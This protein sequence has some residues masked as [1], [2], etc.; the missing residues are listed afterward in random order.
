MAFGQAHV[1][2]R[3]ELDLHD[4]LVPANAARFIKNLVSSLED[5]SGESTEGG[6]QTGVYKPIKSNAPYVAD[7]TPPPGN[8]HPIGA[9]SF[10]D[11]KQVFFFLYNDQQNFSVY[12]I[13][14]SDQTIDTVYLKST[15]NF[16]LNPENFIHQGAC[17][18]E[19]INYTDPT[20]G[21]TEERTFL[22]FT[23]NTNPQRAICVE[24]SIATQG[25]NPVIFPYFSGDYDPMI[26]INMGVATPKG[27]IGISEVPVTITSDQ[28]PNKLLYNTWQFRLRDYD[29]WG[30]PSQYGTISDMYIPSTDCLAMSSG[31]PNCLNLE[32]DA[33]PPHINQIEIAFR[34]C[35]NDQWYTSK[36]IDLYDASPLG[37]WWTRNRNPSVNY[38]SNTNKITFQFCA[39]EECDVIAPTDADT[40]DNGLPKTSMAVFPVGQYIGLANNKEGFNPIPKATLDKITITVEPPS[41]TDPT[42]NDFRNVTIWVQIYNFYI[43][44]GGSIINSGKFYFQSVNQALDPSY[45]Q[46]FQNV[47]Q[48]GFIGY[49]AGTNTYAISEQYIMDRNGNFQKITD[50]KQNEMSLLKG[51][52]FQKFTFTNISKGQYIFRIAGLT[53]DPSV[54]SP[55]TIFKTSTFVHGVYPFNIATPTAPVGLKTP[56]SLNK[57][58]LIDV[59]AGDY[60][61]TVDG[62]ILVIADFVKSATAVRAGY[63]RNTSDT[64][65]DQTGIELLR[66]DGGNFGSQFTDHNGY[67]FASAPTDGH[68]GHGFTYNIFGYC[69]CNLISLTN[70]RLSGYQHRLTIDNW[71]QNTIPNCTDLPTQICRYTLISGQ[72]LLCGSSI[73]VPGI[74]VILS[75][76]NSAITD[77][78]GNF[79]IVA[80]DDCTNQPRNDTIY[81]VSNTCN[82]SDCDGNCIPNIPVV[83]GK[84]TSC[85]ARTIQLGTTQVS[86]V[87]QRGPLS[88]GVYAVGAGKFDWLQRT[89]FIDP[90][91]YMT[92]P[93]VQQTGKFAPSRVR[94][95]I[96]PT[97]DFPLELTDLTIW[98]SQ[99]TTIANY[100]TWIV[101]SFL[102]VDNTGLENTTNPTQ[103][104]IYYAS[105]VEYNKQNN[106]NTTV[107]WSFLVANSTNAVTSDKVEFLLNGDGTFFSKSIT[108]LVKYDTVGQF[109][110]INYTSDLAGLVANAIIRLVRPKVCTGTEPYYECCTNIP[111]VNGKATVLS[112]YLN[113]FDTYYVYRQIPVPVAQPVIPPATTITFID[114]VRSLGVPFETNSP[115]DFWGQG[116]AN[117]GRSNTKNEQEVELYLKDEI[118]ISGAL[119]ITNQ[120]NFLNYFAD[121]LKVNFN[122]TQING[123]TAV[124]FETTVG[125]V[126]GSTDHFV[127]GFNDNLMR[128]NQDGTAQAGSITNAFGNPYRK[129]GSNFGCLP[130]DKN[131]IYK[132]DGLVHWLDTSK[133][134]FVQHNYSEAVN[135]AKANPAKGIPGG[136][137]SWLRPKIKE[138]QDFNLQNGNTRYFHG[139]VNPQADEYILTDFTIGNPTSLNNERQ[140]DFTANESIAMGIL[141]KFWRRFYS[142]TPAYYAELEGELTA[143]QF[144][145]FLKGVPYAH[146]NELEEQQYGMIYGQ[147]VVRVIE[148]VMSIE[149]LRNKKPLAIGVF[150]KQGQYFSDRT[151]S[152]TGQLT[153]MLL[154]AWKQASFG[155]YAPF[156]CDLNTPADPNRPDATGQN[157]LMDGNVL[158]GTYI[159]VRLIGDPATDS[160]YTELQGIAL[161]LI[162][163]ITNLET[164]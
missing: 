15:L 39:N 69:N 143:Q 73:G 42:A 33:P 40:I 25:F 149:S 78:N 163:D 46:F 105:L 83:I 103:I 5:T 87:V 38:N 119:S 112:F 27:C 99:E 79:S 104:K 106:F 107:N 115:S 77:Q 110:L 153:R 3:I 52:F 60:D 18:L 101:D 130:F 14:G 4:S 35:N 57:E 75:R 156:L 30:R 144:F 140:I 36:I 131:T 118:A 63:F 136:I 94:V 139:C 17:W 142:C 126:I 151:V 2:V 10:R 61:S 6:A 159:K 24:D 72:V 55:G 37:Q 146:Y 59:C 123:I 102:F 54:D 20:T 155:W 51:I 114:E 125:L 19:L 22:Y 88:G 117:I 29:V 120:L 90:L 150:C 21:L 111:I 53:V 160:A 50:F 132:K 12:R 91:G 152:S 26:L 56:I 141:S 135:V 1:P 44:Q 8:N 89:G 48:A 108:A 134:A 7:W 41:A 71:Y 16:Q 9:F 121:T 158:I 97:A 82:Y 28:Q 62:K 92:I 164:K 70:A 124:F 128:I 58:I 80:Y 98:V 100:I 32:F 49:F 64:T 162:V 133:A 66:V 11:L 68:T 148:P 86:V 95:D 31:A 85:V 43:G 138:V 74:S 47:N 93:T 129:V 76:G 34:N 13:N 109:F 23:D 147:P 45:G 67:F 122:D 96:D 157:V 116:C 154:G 145:S 161:S 65:Q 113:F 84:C 127:V 81:F 137:D